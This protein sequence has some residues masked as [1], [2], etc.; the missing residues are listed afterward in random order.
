[1]PRLDNRAALDKFSYETV[2]LMTLLLNEIN[3]LRQQASLPP[4]TPAQIRQAIRD[5]I[6]AN[7]RPGRA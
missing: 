3:T 7:P 2:M 4:R 6:R 1:M 5:Y